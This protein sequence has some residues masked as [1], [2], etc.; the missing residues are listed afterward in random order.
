MKRSVSLFIV[1]CML[2]SSVPFVYA[3]GEKDDI[4]GLWDEDTPVT[5]TLVVEDNRAALSVKDALYKTSS[6]SAVIAAYDGEGKLTSVKRFTDVSSSF[7]KFTADVP[8]GAAKLKGFVLDADGAPLTEN[9]IWTPYSEQHNILIFCDGYGAAYNTGDVM[10][11]LAEADGIKLDFTTVSYDNIGLMTTAYNLYECFEFNGSTT[12]SSVPST[13]KVTSVRNSKIRR[14]LEDPETYPCDTFIYFTSRDWGVKNTNRAALNITAA[15]YLSKELNRVNPSAKTITVAPTGFY[16]DDTHPYATAKNISYKTFESHSEAA[17]THANNVLAK[18]TGDKTGIYLYD[19]HVYLKNNYGDKG[20]DLLDGAGICPSMPGAYFNACVLYSSIFKK[21]TS[22]IPFSGFIGDE[23]TVAALQ[24]AADGF[25]TSQGIELAPHTET[26]RFAPMR[27]EEADP[28]NQPTEARFEHEVYPEYYDELLAGAFAYYQRFHLVQYDNMAMDRSGKY[29]FYRREVNICTPEDGT[30]QNYLYSDCSAFVYACYVDTFGFNFNGANRCASIFKNTKLQNSCRVWLW[31]GTLE[32]ETRTPEQISES[33]YSALQPGDVI[34]E[35]NAAR[36]GGHIMIYIGN[37]KMIHLTGIHA[38]G[39][40]EN[41]IYDNGTDAYEMI[42]GVLYGKMDEFGKPD[43]WLCPFKNAAQAAAIYRP[44]LLHITPTE[45]GKTRLERMTD[46][47][48][49][50]LT[51][52]PQGVSVSPGGD[53]SFTVVAYNYDKKARTLEITDTLPSALSLKDKGDFEADGSALSAT[54]TVPAGGEARLSYTVT[55]KGSTP[56]GSSIACR[57]TYVNGIVLNDAPVNVGNTLTADQ[58]A[59]LASAA[60][61]AGSASSTDF[62]FISSVYGSVFGYSMPASSNTA[63]FT[64][65][66]TSKTETSGNTTYNYTTLNKN[67]PYLTLN[68]FGGQA[69]NCSAPLRIKHI[70]AENFVAGDILIFAEELDGS[71]AVSYLYL[72]NGSFAT[73]KNGAYAVLSKTQSL[74]LTQAL[75]SR[76]SFFVFRPSFLF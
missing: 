66:F 31:D 24:A 76:S 71:D 69:L 42:N 16:E 5:S 62:E 12:Y 2:L 18:C 49:Y 11:K 8:E 36:T 23:E 60:Q 4:T 75:P 20:I 22:G 53:V 10:M 14:I 30:P 58:Q 68:L 40:G 34:D 39:G 74:V 54:V 17:K 46:I 41:Y 29:S 21:A 32:G 37:G 3:A 59:A 50:K 67:S 27:L 33:F 64:N 13:A 65:V 72:G 47:V 26:K 48:A 35:V 70:S 73:V 19:A 15:E 56:N 61:A 25:V 44:S 9:R 45:K 28:R 43:G 38:S 6:L 7:N 52:A 55:V 1:L 63:L 51:T 57:N